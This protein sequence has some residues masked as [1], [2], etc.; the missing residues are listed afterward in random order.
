M[1]ERKASALFVFLFTTQK[2]FPDLAQVTRPVT[3][4]Y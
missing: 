4:R 1:Y 3:V 2:Y